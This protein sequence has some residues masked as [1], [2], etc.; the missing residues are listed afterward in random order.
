MNALL[1]SVIISRVMYVLSACSVVSLFAKKRFG[2]IF[3]KWLQGN[4]CW[5]PAFPF[6]CSLI[7]MINFNPKK[8]L[9]SLDI[10]RNLEPDCCEQIFVWLISSSTKLSSLT[11]FLYIFN[12]EKFSEKLYFTSGSRSHG[13]LLSGRSFSFQETALGTAVL[14]FFFPFAFFYSA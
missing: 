4:T 10:V 7:S 2:N 9:I 14:P 8:V 13:F 11:T 1:K 5:L 12:G 3:W 6:R